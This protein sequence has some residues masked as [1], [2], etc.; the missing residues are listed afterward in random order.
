MK[1][2][3]KDTETIRARAYRLKIENL[4]NLNDKQA[5]QENIYDDSLIEKK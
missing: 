3:R 1:E 2:G 5:I 4:G